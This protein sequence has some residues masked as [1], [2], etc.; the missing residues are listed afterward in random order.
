[1]KYTVLDMTQTVLSATDGDEINSIHDTV[2]S[3][4]VATIIRTAFFDM[5][6][7]ANLPVQNTLFQLEASGDSNKPV[8]MYMPTDFQNMATLKYNIATIDDETARMTT[9]QPLCLEDF[10]GQMHMI[11]TTDDNIETFDHTIGTSTI[12]FVYYN[13][14]AP[15]YYTTFDD[16]TVVFDAYNAEVDATLQKSKTLCFGKKNVTWEMTDTFVPDLD[17]KQFP[18]LLNEAKS[19]AFAETKQVQHPLA[20]RNA[21]R[22]WVNLQKDKTKIQ[23]QSDLDRL[24]DF[25]RK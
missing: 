8:L 20:D 3:M 24:P 2:E 10:L 1:M 21:R 7:R 12:T 9:L 11:D 19:L 18:L 13:D 15:K 17:D 5:I 14:I 16:Y 6:N 22:G 4:Q 23:L 25:G